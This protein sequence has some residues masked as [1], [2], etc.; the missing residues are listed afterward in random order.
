MDAILERL[1]TST[2]VGDFCVP[3]NLKLEECR[4][5][6]K[7]LYDKASSLR[8]YG[9]IAEL[10]MDVD[11]ESLWQE[12]QSRDKPLIRSIKRRTA[13]MMRRLS[14]RENEDE[15]DSRKQDAELGGEEDDESE[16]EHESS[17]SDDKDRAF[18]S[19]GGAGEDTSSENDDDDIDHYDDD[20]GGGFFSRFGNRGELDD[21]NE[22]EEMDD[23]GRDD[24]DEVSDGDGDTFEDAHV[25]DNDADSQGEERME[26]E[27]D[28]LGAW[29]D[30]AEEEEMRRIDREERNE[31]K[32]HS[33][34][35]DDDD[36]D[37]SEDDIDF[38]ERELY[39]A[40]AG[41]GTEIMFDDFFGTGRKKGKSTKGSKTTERGRSTGGFYYTDDLG[42]YSRNATLD[43]M[44]EDDEYRNDDSDGNIDIS[45]ARLESDLESDEK[46]DS[47]SS[48]HGGYNSDSSSGEKDDARL[49][50][51][52][53]YEAEQEKMKSTI[54][55]LEADLVKEKS[56]DL[57]GEAKGKER[58]ENSLLGLNV[59]VEKGA[60]PAP[61]ITKEHTETLED[62]IIRRI[63]EEKYDDVVPRKVTEITEK[64]VF[65][66]SQEKSKIG[67][68]DLYAEEYL[69]KTLGL[70]S[71]TS[72][73]QR[74]KVQETKAL[75]RKVSQELDALSHF[76]Y[77]PIPDVEEAKVV[78]SK[79]VSSLSIEDATPVA[80]S[81]GSTKAPE[82]VLKKKTGRNAALLSVEELTG[83]D[84]KRLRRATKA[85]TRKQHSADRAQEEI[86]AKLD[87]QSRAARK[88]EERRMRDD[89]KNDKRVVAGRL[90]ANADSSS[91]SSAFFARMQD[92]ARS[93]IQEKSSKKSSQKKAAK[94]TI[95][96]R[97]FKL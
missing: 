72:V 88:V 85:K 38:V 20:E 92:A 64:D 8:V 61:I 95:S 58:P 12:L 35:N 28:A 68:G 46:S 65:D 39:D 97:K 19:V 22:E 4:A 30:V 9:P 55:Q 53:G 69:T 17:E 51:L 67:L 34:L 56:W 50:K 26:K 25:V 31:K 15:D 33:G 57:R 6:L 27:M 14:E 36:S 23:E 83:D 49:Q 87:P 24:Y 84:K 52:S 2:E 90:D 47:S 59:Q 32:G 40:D 41:D 54:A 3:N 93:E 78:A 43:P 77:A 66:L 86:A 29:L 73:K 75:F 42:E 63:K 62:L 76:F 13:K 16:S 60:K 45:N 71:S 18:T 44:M 79:S 11:S 80:E 94:A 82:E 74:E 21:D 48:Q 91:K 96:S 81:F 70:E 1:D 10:Y 37:T 7:E 89:V 5:L